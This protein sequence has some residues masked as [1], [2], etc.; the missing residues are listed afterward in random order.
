M[1]G[2][3][4]K[5]GGERVEAAQAGQFWRDLRDQTDSFFLPSLADNVPLWRLS[6]PSNTPPLS[7]PGDSLME[8]GG[9]LRWLASHAD[10]RTVRDVTAKAGGHA[11]LFRSDDKSAGVFHPLSP[12]L[13]KIHRN[14]KAEFDP[15][16]VFNRGRMYA[17]F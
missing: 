6:V 8:W 4:D 3:C 17:D 1:S 15:Q 5:L 10:A 13:L 7:L 11:S 12:A 14:L 9:A 2:A 16:G